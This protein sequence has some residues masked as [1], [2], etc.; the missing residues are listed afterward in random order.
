DGRGRFLFNNLEYELG[1]RIEAIK[2]DIRIID[3]S[4][5]NIPSDWSDGRMSASGTISTESFAINE[6]DLAVNGRLKV[7]GFGSR[8]VLRTM[9]GDLFISTG[10][11]ELTYVGRLDRS[12][13]NGELVIERGNLMIPMEQSAGEVGRFEDITYVVVDD[14]TK[15]RATSL[16]AG[17]FARLAATTE[18]DDETPRMPERSVLDGLTFDLLLSTS[19]RLNLVIP[20]S[21]L[22]EELNAQLEIS[23]LKI[24]NWGGSGVKFVGEVTL[25]PDSYFIFLGKRMTASGSLRFMRDPL[26]PDLDLRAVYSDYYIDPA[27]QVRRPVFVIVSITGTMD[28]MELSYDLRYDDVDGEPVA[29]AADV[30]SDVVSFLVFGVFTKDV[31]GGTGDRSSLADKSPEFLNQIT[32]SLASSAATEFLTRAGLREYI[33]RVDFAGLGT[34]ESRVKLTSEIGRAIITYDGR[35]NDLESSNVSVD[36]PLSRVLGIP[37]TNLMI[38]VSRKALNETYQSTTQTQQYSIWELKILQRF[39]F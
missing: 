8:S 30:K 18:D 26:N 16:S 11:Q 4:I 19:G 29:A 17:R 23:N 21:V 13:L 14:T 7:L 22:Q 3:L 27:T 34:E 20:F 5:A 32:S 9:Y 37:W 39:T 36:F 1:L 6:F 38:Q 33:K 24:D 15:Q 35:I 2:Q 31:S 25:G 10:S 12:R 28:E